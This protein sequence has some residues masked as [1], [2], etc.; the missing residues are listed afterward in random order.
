MGA[1][2]EEAFLND[3]K[4]LT[5]KRRTRIR[6]TR[7]IDEDDESCNVAELLTTEIDE[8]KTIS[9]AWGGEQS[10]HWQEAT[11]DEDSS[12]INNN[13]CELVPL[14]KSKKAVGSQ[15]IFKVKRKADGSLDRYKACLV[16]QGF[17]QE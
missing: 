14:P 11:D 2:Y 5:G 6:P 4:S 1:P 10:I 8:P 15:W 12:L 13:A 16:A 17:S 9:E 7:L 3:V